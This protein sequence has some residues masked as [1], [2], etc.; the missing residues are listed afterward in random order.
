[1]DKE[2]KRLLKVVG[3]S[4]IVGYCILKPNLD[5]MIGEDSL[6]SR[7]TKPIALFLYHTKYDG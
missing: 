4:L 6:W 5:Y 1:M 3:F 7:L 2:S